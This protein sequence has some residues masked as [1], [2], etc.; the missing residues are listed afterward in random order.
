MSVKIIERL[1]RCN[2]SDVFGKDCSNRLCN[3]AFILKQCYC[4][5]SFKTI[6]RKFDIIHCPWVS[7]W[8]NSFVIVTHVDFPAS[9]L[10]AMSRKRP[11]P[12]ERHKAIATRLGGE[13]VSRKTM[14][15]LDISEATWFTSRKI[16]LCIRK[17]SFEQRDWRS[18]WRMSSNHRNFGLGTGKWPI[19][20]F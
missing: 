10:V 18:S 17:C 12:A 2:N 4:P 15:L 19:F 7:A 14:S 9:K 5:G 16:S 3:F 20:P 8:Q 11:L 1:L 13:M 6:L